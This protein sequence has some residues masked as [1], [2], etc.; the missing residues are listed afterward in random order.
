MLLISVVLVSL[1]G[2][3]E[4]STNSNLEQVELGQSEQSILEKNDTFI[5]PVINH[6]RTFTIDPSISTIYEN[7]TINPSKNGNVLGDNA[8]YIMINENINP[9]WSEI[10]LRFNSDTLVKSVFFIDLSKKDLSAIN[11]DKNTL[12]NIKTNDV[13]DFYKN[14]FSW[15]ERKIDYPA[16]EMLNKV[17][18]INTEESDFDNNNKEYR[19]QSSYL[20][21][22]ECS[23]SIK[24]VN[25]F[26]Y[27][28]GK[29]KLKFSY[30]LLDYK[31]TTK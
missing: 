23:D 31:L 13:D 27:S 28:C 15:G 5:L 2:C 16:S 1:F 3:N 20:I 29:N 26:K 21:W 8:F 22:F 11:L 9:T 24:F 6:H 30:K 25:E 19:S 4:K 18:V 14:E 12:K 10:V 7:M 17:Y